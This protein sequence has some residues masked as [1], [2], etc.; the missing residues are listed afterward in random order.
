MSHACKLTKLT[1]TWQAGDSKKR[2]G[3]PTL[4]P[5]IDLGAT[6]TLAVSALAAACAC[7]S[8]MDAWSSVPDR[9]NSLQSLCGTKCGLLPSN[10]SLGTMPA[11]GGP[12]AMG[13]LTGMHGPIPIPISAG[14]G[15]MGIPAGACSLAPMLAGPAPVRAGVTVPSCAIWNV[16]LL[17]GVAAHLAAAGRW[18]VGSGVTGGCRTDGAGFR[19][20]G[21]WGHAERGLAASCGVAGGCSS[22]RDAAGTKG[23]MG[24]CTAGLSPAAVAG[25]A[26]K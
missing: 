18:P 24:C 12:P 21:G 13:V 9:G 23:I 26:G 11:N 19:A 22:R 7:A 14:G 10:G 20:R 3:V 4:E 15:R 17:Q 1:S 8:C 5:P 2:M 16:G 6:E 25:V